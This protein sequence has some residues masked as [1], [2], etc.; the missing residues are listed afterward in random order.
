MKK[1]YWAL[2]LGASSGFGADA[3]CLFAQEGCKVV[4][5]ARRIDKLRTL[6]EEIRSKGGVAE[7]IQMDVT[8]NEQIKKTVDEVIH[9]F[10]RVDILINNAG[11]GRLDWLENLEPIQDIETQIEVNLGGLILMTRTVLP[12]MIQQGSGTIIN[13]S[14]VAGRLAAPLYSVYAAT[15]FGVRG[16]TEVLRR[17]VRPL[18]IQVSGIYPGG[19]ATEFGSHTGNSAFRRNVKTPPWLRMTSGYVAKKIVSLA[20]NPKR[21]MVIP[22]WMSIAIWVDSHCPW[23]VDLAFSKMVRKYHH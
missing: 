1:D 23:L 5:T 19:A 18:G 15:K 6:A 14:S 2:I 21:S 12:Y 8:D 22:G 16:F 11:F 4:L 13:M 7:A 9:E 20:K 10:G 17:E 3:A